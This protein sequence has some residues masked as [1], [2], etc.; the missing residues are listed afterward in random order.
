MDKGAHFHNCDFQVHSPRDHNWSGK[1]TVSYEERKL[2]AGHCQRKVEYFARTPTSYFA[3]IDFPRFFQIDPRGS[4]TTSSI[5][6]FPLTMPRTL[7][8]RLICHHLAWK[9]A[10][11]NPTTPEHRQVVTMAPPARETAWTDALASTFAALAVLGHP[12]ERALR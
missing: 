3:A 6:N 5:Q 8:F 1:R 9:K 2:Y 12:V 10:S 11:T 4:M 7:L